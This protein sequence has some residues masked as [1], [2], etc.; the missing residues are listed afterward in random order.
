MKE[1]KGKCLT[2]LQDNM[3]PFHLCKIA[4]HLSWPLQH[5]WEIGTCP[6]TRPSVPDRW[7]MDAPFT[8]LMLHLPRDWRKPVVVCHRSALNLESLLCCCCVSL[9]IKQLCLCFSISESPQHTSL[10]NNNGWMMLYVPMSLKMYYNTNQ[11]CFTWFFFHPDN[12]PTIDFM[13]Y[14]SCHFVRSF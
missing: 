11:C 1:T 8:L 2:I 14:C 9:K 13:I 12:F 4:V 5:T 10:S 6:T 3:H 7:E